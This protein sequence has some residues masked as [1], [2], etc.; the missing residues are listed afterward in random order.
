MKEQNLSFLMSKNVLREDNASFAKSDEVPI[1]IRVESANCRLLCEF[2][3]EIKSF[4]AKAKNKMTN[5]ARTEL[6]LKK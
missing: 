2:H 1:H 6:Y 5:N 3:K 4:N